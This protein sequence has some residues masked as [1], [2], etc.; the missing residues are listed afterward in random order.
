MNKIFKSFC[1]LFCALVIFAKP[2]SSKLNLFATPRYIPNLS[3]YSDSGKKHKLTDNKE[4]IL[5]AMVWSRTCGPCIGDM[6]HLQN[7][8]DKTKDKGIKVILI[9]P[10][11]EWKTIDERRNFLTRIGAPRLESYTDPKSGFSHGMGIMVTPTAIMVSREGEE[12]GQITGSV[13]WDDPDVIDYIL[14]LKEDIYKK[15]VSK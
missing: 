14:N 10:A 3:Y 8:A 13:K 1:F 11:E 9:S 6:K 15:P 4:D 12:I 7:F 5:I 2:A